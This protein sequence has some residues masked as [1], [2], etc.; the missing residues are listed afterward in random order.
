MNANPLF[1]V[2]PESDPFYASVERIKEY[3]ETLRETHANARTS[4]ITMRQRA[5]RKNPSLFH[6]FSKRSTALEEDMD[7]LKAQSEVGKILLTPMSEALG[8]MQ[9]EGP[10]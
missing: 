5:G 8:A 4:A 2:T 10:R 9:D 3:A 6:G 7:T 1:D